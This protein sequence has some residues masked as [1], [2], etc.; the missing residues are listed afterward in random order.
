MEYHNNEVT[1]SV[2][3]NDLIDGSFTVNG[4]SVTSGQDPDNKIYTGLVAK[5]ESDGKFTFSVGRKSSTEVASWFSSQVSGDK[6]TFDEDPGELNFAMIGTLVL[7]FSNGINC[8]FYNIAIAQGH[9]GA[10]NNWWFGGQ[11]A[12]Y[13]GGNTVICGASSNQQS[14]IPLLQFQ[15][16]GIGNDVG[17]VSVTPKTF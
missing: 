5:C 15:R 6:T 12:M 8:T 7:N 3:S 16:G 2:T 10:S 11:Q 13:N 9:S 1:F 17:T 4:F 14:N